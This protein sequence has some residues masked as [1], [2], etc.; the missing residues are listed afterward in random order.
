MFK[1]ILALARAARAGSAV[2]LVAG[3]GAC[4]SPTAM[5][6]MLQQPESAR[7]AQMERFAVAP[8]EGKQGAG[9][10]ELVAQRLS[11]HRVDGRLR[12]QVAAIAPNQLQSADADGVIVGTVNRYGVSDRSYTE[13][14]SKCAQEGG[15]SGGFLGQLGA[16]KCLRM[17]DYN[18]SCLERKA[19]VDVSFRVIARDGVSVLSSTK[20]HGLEQRGCENFKARSPD[21]MLGEATAVVARQIVEA[22]A[23]TEKLVARPLRASTADLGDEASLKFKLGM[24]YAA[25]GDLA[26][27]CALWDEIELGGEQSSSLNFNLAVCDESRG[28]VASAL[29]RIR[30]AIERSPEVDKELLEE[31]RRYEALL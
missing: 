8:F 16:R 5:V 21:E 22:I 9:F 11:E 26:R 18:V 14:R 24:D 28:D 31:E 20:T 3:L 7:T 30:E 12:F 15:K 27:A 10:A 17:Q 6:P 23:P 13:Q 19:V 1:A 2:A 4:A 29:A 25:A